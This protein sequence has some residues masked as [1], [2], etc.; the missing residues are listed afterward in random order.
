MDAGKLL[1][2][3]IIFTGLLAFWPQEVIA[4]SWPQT[5]S[6]KEIPGSY[7]NLKLRVKVF[8]HR[9]DW[10]PHRKDRKRQ[11]IELKSTSDCRVYKGLTS[12]T[13]QAKSKFYLED[14]IKIHTLNLEQPLWIECDDPATLKRHNKDVTDYSYAGSFYVYRHWN[15][16]HK[17]FEVT[18]I[19]IID[20][21]TYLRGVVPSEVFITW[22]KDTLKTQAVAARTYAMFHLTVA[23]AQGRRG[24]QRFYDVDD[25]VMFQA[26]TGLSH[27]HP[28]TDKAIKDTH[29]LVLTHNNGIIQAYYHADSGGGITESAK[30]VWGTEVPYAKPVREPFRTKRSTTIQW[31]TTV[32]KGELARRLKRFGVLRQ[33]E[34]ITYVAPLKSAVTKSGRVKTLL[35]KTTAGRYQR[36]STKRIKKY[37]SLNSNKFE[38]KADKKSLY[39]VG[40]GSGHGVGL[41]QRG[42][43]V[44]SKVKGWSYRQILHH[45]Y[46]QTQVCALTPKSPTKLPQCQEDS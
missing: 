33:G 4:Q 42:A 16:A 31:K 29:S 36:I 27:T 45:Y 43:Q 24:H 14:E 13:G 18:V 6:L 7:E 5:V 21:E 38:I 40:R 12:K 10:I 3:A 32:T 44:L 30:S 28:R 37:I 19:N 22:T 26:Y 46:T 17:N 20:I 1:S 23:R 9:K 11:Y 25:T 35:I 41:N 8:P 34:Q 39:F 15:K 2:T